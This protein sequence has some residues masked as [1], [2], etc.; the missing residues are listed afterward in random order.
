MNIRDNSIFS[1]QE[2]I[3]CDDNWNLVNKYNYASF[4]SSM[5]DLPFDE[6]DKFITKT[7]ETLTIKHENIKRWRA[8]PIE[9]LEDKLDP[10]IYKLIVAHDITNLYE[11]RKNISRCYDGKIRSMIVGIANVKGK[12]V[13]DALDE[14]DPFLG[15][16]LYTER[17]IELNTGKY[18]I[19]VEDA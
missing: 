12:A 17:W 1:I 6:L 19:G 14:F 7:I 18:D 13:L 3:E 9:V 2:V 4:S 10:K 5:L 11:L 15:K 8:T 16:S